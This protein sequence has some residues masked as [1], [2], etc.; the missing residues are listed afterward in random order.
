MLKREQTHSF[1]FFHKLSVSYEAFV[2]LH[3]I[4][5]THGKICIGLTLILYEIDA[6]LMNNNRIAIMLYGIFIII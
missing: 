6:L 2:I 1:N 5:N 3:W 4:Y